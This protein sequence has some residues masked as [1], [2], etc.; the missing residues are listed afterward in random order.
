MYGGKKKKKTTDC[1]ALELPSKIHK[2][3]KKSKSKVHE[4]HKN[5]MPLYPLDENG[6]PKMPSI[7]ELGNPVSYPGYPEIEYNFTNPT[8]DPNY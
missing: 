1:T 6:K 4:E 8:G 5:H 2:N 7:E 3:M